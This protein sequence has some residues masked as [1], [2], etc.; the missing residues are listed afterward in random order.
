MKS[1][2]DTSVLIAV[3]LGDHVHHDASLRIFAAATKNDAACSTHTLA[4]VFAVLSALPL[5]PPISAEQAGLFVGE[6]YQRLTPVSLDADE[7]F[8]TVQE[9]AER[10]VAGG[11]IYDALL[12]QSAR[13]CGAEM[14]YTWNLKHFQ[15]IAPDLAQRMRNP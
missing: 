9:A 8:Q 4:E 5:K 14:I 7:C 6:V 1:F 3:F 10:G 2:F 15:A 12:L 11:R 13:K